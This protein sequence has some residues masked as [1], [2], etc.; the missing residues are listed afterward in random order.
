MSNSCDN[1]TQLKQVRARCVTLTKN[2]DKQ[3]LQVLAFQKSWRSFSHITVC[4]LALCQWRTLGGG[5]PGRH[6]PT[7][8]PLEEAVSVLKKYFSCIICTVMVWWRF[9][10]FWGGLRRFNGQHDG[11]ANRSNSQTSLPRA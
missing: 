5:R 6:L 2:K 11:F 10:V 7:P 3:V 9:G 8:P 1:M 4:I